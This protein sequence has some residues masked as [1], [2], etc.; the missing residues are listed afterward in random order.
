MANNIRFVDDLKVG[1]YTVSGGTGGTVIDNNFNNYVLTATGND[2]IEGN[3]ALQF[4]GLN[5]GIGG[6]SNGARFEINDTTGRDLVLIK[7]ANNQGIKVNNE[8]IFQLIKFNALP[9]TAPEG[10]LAISANNFYV[11]L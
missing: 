4:D 6:P 2:N 3:S 8:G 11:G 7:N 10:G 9:G 5:L 1:A